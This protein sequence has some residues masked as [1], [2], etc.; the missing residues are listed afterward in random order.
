MKRWNSGVS[1]VLFQCQPLQR[2]V[3][4]SRTSLYLCTFSFFFKGEDI[5]IQD[6]SEKLKHALI[7]LVIDDTQAT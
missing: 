3:S 4:Q 1:Q 5:L 6:A 7:F 2:K